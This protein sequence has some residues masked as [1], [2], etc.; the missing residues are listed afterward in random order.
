MKN[1]FCQAGYFLPVVAVALWCSSCTTSRFY[2]PNTMQV[3]TLTGAKEGTLSGGI[4]KSDNH[5]GWD[6]QA[7]YSPLPH[8]GLMVNHFQA[9]SETQ[10][11]T[12]FSSSFFESTCTSKASFTEAGL[13]GYYPAGPSKEYLLSLFAGFGSGKMKNSYSAP[14]DPPNTEPYISD[15]RYQRWFVQPSLGLKYR[16]FQVGTGIRLVW[17]N[18][19]DGHINSRM[20]LFETERI[21]LLEHSSPMFL[22]EMAW[23][24][25]LRLRPLVLSLNSTSVVRGNNAL[26]DLDLATNYVSI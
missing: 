9:K 2:T 25:G 8:L 15:W 26:R 16:R 11:L 12:E 4:S 7:I 10:V 3:P 19:L 1:K 20:G 5:T 14:P 13:G 22:T 6:V 21:Q 24:I 17:V 23:S 18:F